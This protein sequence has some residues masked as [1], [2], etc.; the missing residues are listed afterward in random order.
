MADAPRF[1]EQA[2]HERDE[3][4][5]NRSAELRTSQVSANKVCDETSKKMELEDAMSGCTGPEQHEGPRKSGAAQNSMKGAE[6]RNQAGSRSRR[7]SPHRNRS[8]RWDW[9]SDEKTYNKRI[10]KLSKATAHV[11]RYGPVEQTWN[12]QQEIVENFKEKKTPQEKS[13]TRQRSER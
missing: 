3:E 1:A 6:E 8:K 4:E 9:R 5:R 13:L 11:V 7:T 12:D 10:T 2:R